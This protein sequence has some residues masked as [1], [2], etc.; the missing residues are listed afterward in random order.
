MR[1]DRGIVGF[2]Y[3]TFRRRYDARDTILYALGVGAGERE[4][5]LHLVYERDLTALPSVPVAPPYAALAGMHDRLGIDLSSVLHGEQRLRLH[6]AVPVEGELSVDAR[7]SAVWD[8]GEH[9]IVDTT[10]EVR[11]DGEHLATAVYSSFI[12]G[13]GG[14][15]GERG[16]GLRAPARDRPPDVV[17][18]ERTHTGQARLYRLSG[19][20]NP[21]HV[22]PQFARRA[23]FDRPILHGLCTYGY[24]VRMALPA[25]AGGDPARVRRADARFTDVVYPGDELRLELWHTGPAEVSA[26]VLVPAREAVVIDPIEL[27]ALPA[28]NPGARDSPTSEIDSKGAP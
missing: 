8:K 20:D 23:G 3:P 28:M 19:D 24:A 10:A 2:A 12:R 4:D 14:F 5:E 16:R 22:D 27:S 17:L 21:L 6:R 7:V 18:T 26:R 13:G 25:I 9:A 11:V 1:V 15:G